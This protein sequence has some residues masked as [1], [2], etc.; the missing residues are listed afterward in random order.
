M[1]SGA[2]S[3]LI[4]VVTFLIINQLFEYTLKIYIFLSIL[5]YIKSKFTAFIIISSINIKSLRPF[6]FLISSKVI[7]LFLE[8]Y[9]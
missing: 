5:P 9:E 7:I 2:I 8:N 6:F 4:H 3:R 1:P